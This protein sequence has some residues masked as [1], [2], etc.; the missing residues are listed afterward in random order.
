MYYFAYGSNMLR[1]RLAERVGAVAVAGVGT[2]SGHQLRFHK[3]SHDGSAKCNLYYTGR[4]FDETLGVVYDL[5]ADQRTRLDRHEGHGYCT[6]S[7]HVTLG[8]RTVRAV[9]YVAT[10]DFLDEE[11]RPYDWYL[12]F[13]ITGARQHGLDSRYVDAIATVAPEPDR[14]PAR[15]A[16]NARLLRW[17][18]L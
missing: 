8:H 3:R 1:P 15:A 16:L 6:R 14:V 9:T 4:G 5:R 18:G 13:V 12:A 10:A 11:L 2:V 7:V 17:A